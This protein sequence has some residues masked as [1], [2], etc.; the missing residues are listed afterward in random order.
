METILVYRC[1]NSYGGGAFQTLF[2]AAD[3]ANIHNDF[4]RFPPPSEDP[5]LKQ[6]RG[7]ADFPG[8][9]VRFG[10]ADRE[11]FDEWFPPSIYGGLRKHHMHL[12]VYAVPRDHVV[13]GARQVVF[14]RSAATLVETVTL[15]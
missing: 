11:Q 10:C 15:Q 1:E 12:S 3:Y 6:Y 2:S 13:V 5:L 14:D 8:W 7:D 9:T 4:A